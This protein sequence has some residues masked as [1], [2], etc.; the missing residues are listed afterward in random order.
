MHEPSSAERMQ[1]LRWGL[2]ITKILLDLPV[3]TSTPGYGTIFFKSFALMLTLHGCWV[4]SAALCILISSPVPLFY[5]ICVLWAW[6]QYWLCFGFEDQKPCLVK[7]LGHLM[8]IHCLTLKIKIKENRVPKS[9][10]RPWVKMLQASHTS[11]DLWQNLIRNPL[12]SKLLWLQMVLI[13]QNWENVLICSC[14]V[15]PT[16]VLKVSSVHNLLLSSNGHLL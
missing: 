9:S 16:Y 5:L 6:G 15:P 12:G 11:Q 2:G 13:Q 10:F 8:W 4:I 7:Q 1:I 14:Y 3:W